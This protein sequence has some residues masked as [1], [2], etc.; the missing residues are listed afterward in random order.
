MITTATNAAYDH[1]LQSWHMTQRMTQPDNAKRELIQGAYESNS[2]F[3]ARMRLTDF[4]PL[5]STILQRLVGM[6]Y[7]RQEDIE[8]DTPLDLDN[9]GAMGESMNTIASEIAMNLLLYNDAVVVV[10]SDGV[11]VSPPIACPR[12]QEG[13]FFTIRSTRQAEAVGPAMDQEIRHVWTVY[14]SGGFTIY[15]QEENPQGDKED[16]VVQPFTPWNPDDIE[17]VFRLRQD[18]VPPVLRPEMHWERALGAAIARGHRAIY[19]AES[20][21]DTAELEAAASTKIQAGVG[22]DEDLAEA[23]AEA[24][25]RD[26]S[27]V[28][29]SDEMGEHKPLSLPTG[30]SEALRETIQAKERRLYE[31]M[32]ITMAA[33]ANRSATEAM[34]DLS[35]GVAATL[36]TLADKMQDVERDLLQLLEQARNVQTRLGRPTDV[37]VS[38]PSDF[39]NIDL[40]AE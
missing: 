10:E 22:A 26:R 12:W 2:R 28:P 33:N 31:V 30:P 14:E 3:E 5:T 13:S 4:H 21:C 27:Y 16:V 1:M 6:L 17:T 39:S 9:I 24:L 25:K 38:Y 8:R 20:R 19:R 36:S 32:G 18:P 37:S 40:T 35:T 11:K 34:I 23:F 15:G 7:A 29:Y